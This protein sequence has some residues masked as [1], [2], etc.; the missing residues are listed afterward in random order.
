M[1]HSKCKVNILSGNINTLSTGEIAGYLTVELAGAEEDI[2][3]AL[4][5]LSDENVM[6]EVLS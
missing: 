5:K 2:E 1:K 4:M 6:V 3:D